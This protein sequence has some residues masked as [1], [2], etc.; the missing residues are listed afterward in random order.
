MKQVQK[1]FT[2]IELIVVIVILGILAATALPK[3]VNLSTDARTAAMKS[4]EGSM[5]AASAMVYAKAQV[6]NLMTGTTAVPVNVLVNN[7]NIST[8]YGYPATVAALVL[9]MDLGSDFDSTTVITEIESKGAPTPTTC[10]VAYVA[11][12]ST[13]APTFTT[14][15]NGC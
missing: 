7:V 9:A 8:A 12:T 5:R 14:T 10:K 4:V 6:G 15:S 3:F 1:G 2:L 11:A 13:T